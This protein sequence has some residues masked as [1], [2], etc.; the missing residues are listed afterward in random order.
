M[1][2]RSVNS[3]RNAISGIIKTIVKIF[4][5]FA[6]RSVMI[7]YLGKE[8]LGL[9][10]L[11]S[12]I[13]STLN[14]AELGFSS[15][16][17]YRLYG[18]VA[19]KEYKAVGAYLNYLKKVYYIIGIIVIAAGIVIIPFLGMMAKGGYPPDINIYV[20]YLCY[21]VNAGFG[22]CLWGYKRTVIVASQRMDYI[23]IIE[24]AV[25][26]AQYVIQIIAIVIS[27]NYYIYIITLPI[28]T[29]LI[30]YFISQICKKK[31]HI[32]FN[33]NQLSLAEK[34]EMNS[35]VKGVAVYK[36]SE[37]TRNSFDSIVISAT[38]G[39]IA[40]GIYNNY[41]YI[42]GAIYSVMVI[43][44]QSLQPSVGNSIA[45]E[46]VDKNRKELKKLTILSMGLI[47]I[48]CC[49]LLGLYQPF[50][51]MWV[52]KDMLIEEIDMIL[53]CIYFYI[54]N[55]SNIRNLFFDGYGLWNR[56]RNSYII[57]SLGNLVLNIVLGKFFGITGILISTIITMLFCSFIWRS[58]ILFKYYYGNIGFRDY[59]LLHLKILI[60]G[61]LCC[62]SSYIICRYINLDGVLGIIL[63]CMISVIIPVLGYTLYFK[64]DASF[65]EGIEQIK[66]ATSIIIRGRKHV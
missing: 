45:T 61:I 48:S 49:C 15:A 1:D 9:N 36:I 8:Y 12:S 44:N 10:S 28:S 16:V 38:L 53:F 56:G 40:V 57:E 35:D 2:S 59:I 47:I 4:I 33:D 34:K 3:S 21:L 22:Y 18:P 54:L 5:P 66:K 13:L 46:S 23:N 32:F 24:T 41:Y 62:V 29:V 20:I 51:I 60:I 52:G 7:F 17:I 14:M 39:L 64:N 25:F 30:N 31:Y 6:I 11:F 42:F 19:R 65:R 43:I 58:I 37:T 27:K 50:M 55:M 26:T 63:K